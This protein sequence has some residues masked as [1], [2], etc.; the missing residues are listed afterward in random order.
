MEPSRRQRLVVEAVRA[1]TA[2]SS[3]ADV[4]SIRRALA[5]DA[6][7]WP[8]APKF[9]EIHTVGLARA[10]A[11]L[12]TVDGDIVECGVHLGRSVLTLARSSEL[13]SPEKR[14]LGFDCFDAF[15]PASAEDVGPAVDAVGHVYTGLEVPSEQVVATLLDAS[16]ELVAGYFE[17]TIPVRLPRSISLLHV[18][19]DLYE[20]TRHVLDHALPRVSSGGL[21]VLDEYLAPRWPGA[22]KAVDEAADQF[23]LI[24]EWDPTLLRHVLRISEN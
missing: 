8:T 1:A 12:S 20:S 18:D 22:T 2:A 16:V 11:E 5:A 15:P 17:Q 7:C 13:H 6:L 4:A 10:V 24:P 21:V 19:C 3:L 23:G 9:D 14:V